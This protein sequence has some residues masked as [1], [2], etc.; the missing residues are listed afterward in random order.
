MGH[1]AVIVAESILAFL[2]QLEV[3]KSLRLR[4]PVSLLILR[5]EAEARQ[6]IPNPG[7]LAQQLGPAVS[8]VLRGTDAVA[9]SSTSPLLE[10]LLVNA[11]AD[12]L[13]GILGRIREELSR[14]R[15][16]LNGEQAAVTLRIGTA[17]YPRTATTAAELRAQATRRASRDDGE[18]KPQGL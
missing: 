3:Q 6:A 12:D 11:D 8:R 7:H 4:Y 18:K 14:H 5:A 15:F 13:A 16:R 17:C 9:P 2:T 1:S 10:I